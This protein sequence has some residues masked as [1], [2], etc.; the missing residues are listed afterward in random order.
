MTFENMVILITGATGNLGQAL[1][2]S[3][4]GSGSKLVLFDHLRGRLSEMYPDLKDAIHVLFL[5]D[6]DL[7]DHE[8]VRHS[9]DQVIDRF[10]RID[11]VINA[12]GGYQG[13]DPVDQTS[14]EIW[15]Q[16]LDLNARTV[17]LVSRAVLPSMRTQGS[18]VIINVGARPG[19]NGQKNAGAY[20]ASKSAVLR[21]TESISAEVKKDGV[22]VNAVI[23][24]TMDTP[25]N[26]KAMPSA[27]HTDW[28][29]PEAVADVILFLA[30]EQA[31]GICGAYIPVLGAS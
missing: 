21:L 27:N 13:G 23:P 25:E 19:I 2:K 7:T 5:E 14:V 6:T 8:A 12:A 16:M 29:E 15:D 9:I 30:S 4:E 18:G 28:V 24:G 26:R 22:R 3:L 17:F 20:S 10:G 1:V 31:R 11:V